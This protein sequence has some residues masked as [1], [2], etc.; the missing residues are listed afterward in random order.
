MGS[1]LSSRL[2]VEQAGTGPSESRAPKGVLGLVHSPPHHSFPEP[3]VSAP[4]VSRCSS[5]RLCRG[6]LGFRAA[7]NLQDTESQ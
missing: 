7:Q 4:R 6:L 3:V 1:P 5:P 2:R